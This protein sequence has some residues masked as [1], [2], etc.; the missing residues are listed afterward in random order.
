M[1]IFVAGVHGVGKGFLCN[2]YIKNSNVLHK[3]ASQLIRENSN[4]TLT[5]NKLTSGME[6]N[7]KILIAA[8]DKLKSE[9]KILLLDGHFSLVSKYGEV[10]KLSSSV[11]KSINIDMV[12]LIENTK[13][14][15]TKR[16]IERDN[17]EPAYDIEEL[18]KAE[19][20]NANSIC[21]ELNIPLIRL[22]SPTLNEFNDII[23]GIRRE[24]EP[25]A[26][27]SL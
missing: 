12:V 26:F 7:Q 11:F 3:S 13:D 24:I 4:I 2:N 22:M 27:K 16:I 23:D 25:G 5:D 21:T 19:S 9:N 18:I 15:I 20:E 1:L 10:K 14:I 17:S 8:L 6:Q